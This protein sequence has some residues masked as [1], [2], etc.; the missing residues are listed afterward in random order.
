LH[1]QGQRVQWKQG[2]RVHQQEQAGQR[3]LHEG[4]RVQW[5]QGQ[6][7]QRVLQWHQQEQAGLR[8]QDQAGQRVLQ[9]HQQRYRRRP[10]P[11]LR[12]A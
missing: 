7:V 6:R 5:K 2:Q 12:S 9:W 3:V 10:R 1:Q 11:P 8:V 4:Q